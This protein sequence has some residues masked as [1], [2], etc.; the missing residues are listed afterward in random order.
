MPVA[1]LPKLS[2]WPLPLK[3][4]GPPRPIKERVAT[5]LCPEA[6]F[7]SAQK[8]QGQELGGGGGCDSVAWPELETKRAKSTDRSAAPRFHEPAPEGEEP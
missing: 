7:L 8:A 4:K 1:K 2:A 3:A 6:R 5:A